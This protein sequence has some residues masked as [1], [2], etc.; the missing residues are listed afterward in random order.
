MTHLHQQNMTHGV[1]TKSSGCIIIISYTYV[2][3]ISVQK[4]I[5]FIIRYGPRWSLS[6]DSTHV[7]TFNRI[8]FCPRLHCNTLIEKWTT[9]STIVKPVLSDHFHDIQLVLKGQVFLFTMK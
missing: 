5:L 3:H 7:L 4:K 8:V 1:F 2:V 9:I 6:D